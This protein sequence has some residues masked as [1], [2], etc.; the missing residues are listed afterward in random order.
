MPEY[1]VRAKVM[2]Q[3]YKGRDKAFR[4]MYFMFSRK[5]ESDNKNREEV[6]RAKWFI[7]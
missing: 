3:R 2:F 6:D 5:Y 4:E 1:P 7:V